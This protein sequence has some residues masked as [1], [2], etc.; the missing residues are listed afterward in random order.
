MDGT[1]TGEAS[2]IAR[3][4]AAKKRLMKLRILF[5]LVILTIVIGYGWSIV[6]QI[7]NI[8]TTELTV[9]LETKAN[10]LLPRIQ[11]HLGEVAQNLQPTLKGELD[12]QSRVLGP[13]LDRLLEAETEKLKRKLETNFERDLISAV[14]EVEQRQRN[15]LVKY[16]P[17]LRMTPKHRTVCWS[18]SGLHS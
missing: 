18:L 1:P 9:E 16:I 5:P 12:R 13:K 4:Q 6:S 8:D 2:L 7:Q 17:E 14:E 15:V 3:H 11:E 10:V